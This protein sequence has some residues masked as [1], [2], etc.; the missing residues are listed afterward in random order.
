[1]KA[2][3]FVFLAGC[4]FFITLSQG[5]SKDGSFTIEKRHFLPKEISESSGLFLYNNLVWTFNDSDGKPELYGFNLKTDTIEQ[6]ITLKNTLNHDWEEVTQDDR[7][8]YVGDFGNNLG[9]RDTL[10]IYK[11]DKQKI[12][13]RK[14]VQVDVKRIYFTYPGYKPARIP[15]SFSAFDCEAFIEKGDSLYLF[16]KDWTSGTCTIYAIPK[17]PGNYMARKI[18]TF[19]SNGLVTGASFVKNQL[20]II[21]YNNFVPFIMNF[22][23]VTSLAGISEKSAQR[24]EFEK[25]ATYQTEGIAILNPR[26][27]LISC[28]K[29]RVPAQIIEIT[30]NK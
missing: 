20:I 3:F 2:V 7:Y 14:H 11:I 29:T 19:N 13:I 24:I 1:M 4:N 8:I 26:H 18:K 6:I 22:P 12:P 5:Q 10:L 30:L 28:E 25:L 17:L 9:K 23:N 16:S 27:I 21:G 15:S